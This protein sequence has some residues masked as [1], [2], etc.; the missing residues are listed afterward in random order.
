MSSRKAL[1]ITLFIVLIIVIIGSLFMIFNNKIT[2]NVV[3]DLNKYTLT[4]AICND[5]NYCED[6]VIECKGE[7]RVSITPT[8]SVIQHAEDWKDPRT[9]E[10]INQLC[11]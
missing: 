8:G 1:I 2:G 7:E 10:S 4:K 3:E 9:Q 6:Y 5:T 11:N